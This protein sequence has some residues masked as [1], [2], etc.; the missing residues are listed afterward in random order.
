LALERAKYQQ[1]I[2]YLKEV[3]TGD[4]NNPQVNQMMT[5]AMDGFNRARFYEL[6]SK[7]KQSQRAGKDDHALACFEKAIHADPTSMDA[8]HLLADLLLETRSDLLRALSMARDIVSKGGQQARYFATLGELY[9]LNKQYPE[10]RSAL[11]QALNITPGNDR[12]KKLLKACK[13]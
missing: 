12:Y 4:P 3:Q 8:R 6:L 13:K 2:D 9:M 5:K 10:A 11:E 7:G 1:A